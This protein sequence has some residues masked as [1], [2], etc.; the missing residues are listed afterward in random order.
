MKP[1]LDGM[2][3]GRFDAR[4]LETAEKVSKVERLGDR[5]TLQMS[6]FLDDVESVG[7][8]LS[9]GELSAEQAGADLAQMRGN[10]N[11]W[12]KLAC[13]NLIDHPVKDA[14]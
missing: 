7:R 12:V 1:D 8:A 14:K 6:M 10:L 13:G 9:S 4:V 11:E 2:V 3:R 5:L